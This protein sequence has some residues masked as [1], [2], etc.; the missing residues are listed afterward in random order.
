MPSSN[1]R[2]FPLLLT[3]NLE[4]RICHNIRI[5]ALQKIKNISNSTKVS[6]LWNIFFSSFL[7]FFLFKA[8]P[9]AYG[10]SWARGWIGAAVKAYTTATAMPDPSPICDLCCSLQQLWILN[11]LSKAKDWTCIL[12]D[13]RL[14]SYQLSHN[15]NSWNIFIGE[16]KDHLLTCPHLLYQK[17]NLAGL[18]RK[19]DIFGRLGLKREIINSCQREKW[20]PAEFWD[21][22]LGLLIRFICCWTWT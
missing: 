4:T 15:G 21:I 17:L 7:K 12:M 22:S 11:L 1:L 14:G 20:G 19:T 9:V 3:Y 16:E 6:H 2:N 18:N 5:F 13:T 8:E 10:N